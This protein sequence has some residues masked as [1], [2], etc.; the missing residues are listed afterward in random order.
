M[1]QKELSYLED[2]ISHEESIIKICNNMINS[3][4]DENLVSFIEDEVNVHT[5]ILDNLMELLEEKSNG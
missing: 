5:N 1:T 4:S 2:S 3:L